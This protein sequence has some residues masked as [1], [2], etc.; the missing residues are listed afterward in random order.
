[1]GP[2]SGNPVTYDSWTLGGKPLGKAG[3]YDLYADVFVCTGEECAP[4]RQANGHE[5]VRAVPSAF[6][7]RPRCE[8]Q[9]WSSKTG[10]W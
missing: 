5:P 8:M 10:G 3:V 4:A 6:I 9:M 1:M 2:I 7:R